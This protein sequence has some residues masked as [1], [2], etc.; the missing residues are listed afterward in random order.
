MGS[1]GTVTVTPSGVPP[2]VA[3]ALAVVS[4]CTKLG[5]GKIKWPG[6]FSLSKPLDAEISIDQLLIV[7][8]CKVQKYYGICHTTQGLNASN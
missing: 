3:P 2:W 7:K 6:K 8:T 1:A 5:V 4:L